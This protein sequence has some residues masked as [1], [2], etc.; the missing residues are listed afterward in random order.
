MMAM[1]QAKLEHS[2]ATIKINQSPPQFNL[3]A[4]DVHVWFFPLKG[5]EQRHADLLQA[6]EQSHAQ[7]LIDQQ[8]ATRYRLAHQAKRYLLS[9]YCHMPAQELDFQRQP[10]GKPYLQNHCLQ[11]N[12]SHSHQ[13]AAL[14]IAEHSLGIDIEK[15]EDTSDR[16]Q[17]LRNHVRHPDEN[18]TGPRDFY[19]MWCAKE[20]VSKWDGRG[21]S[22]AFPTLKLI[23]LKQSWQVVD[24]TQSILACQIITIP[25]PMGYMAMLAHETQNANI[26]CYQFKSH[27]QLFEIIA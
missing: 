2:A 11:F 7:R 24:K 12:L 25:A 23:Q 15:H 5:N 1:N 17:R 22:M 20:A 10:L 19:R 27:Q 6:D 18:I 13:W 14:A 16:W 4:N 9:R 26:H 8:Q 21:L 3:G